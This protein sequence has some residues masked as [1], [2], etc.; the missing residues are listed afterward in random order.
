PDAATFLAA[1]G[2]NPNFVWNGSVVGSI[3]TSCGMVCW[4]APSNSLPPNPPTWNASLPSNYTDCVSYGAYDGPAIPLRAAPVASTPGNGTFSL[5]RTDS[6]N[7]SNHFAL[8]CP[9]PTN[10]AGVTGSFAPCPPATTT[11]TRPTTTTTTT[12][13]PSICGDVNGDQSV[14]IG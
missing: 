10:N 2:V 9:T 3:P 8:A 13:P 6:G 1:S 4:G 7:F 11:T 14:D 5:T 12:L